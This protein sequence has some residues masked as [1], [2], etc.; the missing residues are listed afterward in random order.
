MHSQVLRK[1]PQ[2]SLKSILVTWFLLFSIVPLAFVTGYSVIKFEKA[3]DYE[4]SQRLKGNAREIDVIL[5]DFETELSQKRDK[6][7]RESTLIYNL[8][9]GKSHSILPMAQSWMKN[10]LASSLSFFDQDGRL[11]LSVFKDENGRLR[12]L[13]PE[14]QELFL[15]DS[16]LKKAKRSLTSNF[17]EFQSSRRVSLITVSQINASPGKRVGFVEQILDLDKTFFQKVKDRM[18]TEI[19]VLSDKDEVIVGSQDD[20]YKYPKGYFRSLLKGRGE[21]FFDADL[22]GLPFGF[23]ID[24][25]KWGDASM[26]VGLGASKFEAKVLLKNL[27]YT[28]YGVVGAVIALLIFLVMIASRIL[29]K[30]LGDLL[31][32]I[33]TFHESDTGVEIPVKNETEI[34]LLTESFNEMSRRITGARTELK[35]KIKELEV[36]NQKLKDAQSKLVQTAKMA[37]L[38]QLVAGVAHELNNPIGF[39][40]SNMGH[41]RDHSKRLT[42]Y[43]RILETKKGDSSK[44]RESLEIDY[45]EK[46]L[47]KLI[48]SCEDGARRIR[49][50]VL[51]LRNFSRI[52][53][54]EFKLCDLHEGLDNTLNL[55]SGEIKSRIEVV[56]K[57]G[58]LPLVECN[59]GQI[60]QVFMNILSNSAQAIEN[61]GT[62]TITTELAKKGKW[63]K[64]TIKDTGKGIPKENLE[65]VFDPFFTTKPVGQG[66]GLGLSITFGIVKNHGGDIQVK[67][68]VG[69]GTEFQVLLPVQNEVT[70]PPEA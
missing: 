3:F 30:P 64:I 57:Y 40:Y 10:D 70:P 2:R 26:A 12:E 47:P 6:Y 15:S 38:G 4:M 21:V 66:T 9:T 39:I 41:L 61:R 29:L 44:Q 54:S 43:I 28:F 27:N 49:D 55:L 56:K 50:I 23:I 16:H 68:I 53:E 11:I 60:N 7:F 25:I 37:S 32:G 18:K 62:I 58:E 24:S 22:R 5:K 1:T 69:Q 51:G 63:I 20:F 33:Q 35:N 14:N 13:I 52:E 36:T 19:F 59:P 45:V 46:D 48:A 17:I 67:S 42:E 34:G 65:K 8:S 31:D